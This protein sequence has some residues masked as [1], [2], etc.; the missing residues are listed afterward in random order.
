MRPDRHQ[1]RNPSRLR[2]SPMKS[3]RPSAFTTVSNSRHALKRSIGSDEDWE[4]R[5]KRIERALSTSGGSPT[6]SM[7]AT[8]P[9]MGQRSTSTSA[10]R[11][12]DL[13]NAAPCSSIW[14]CPKNLSSSTWTT[15]APQTPCHAPPRDVWID[16]AVFRHSDRALC[17]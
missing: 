3:T 16:R 9:S 15:T 14:P 11:S 7:K 8:A 10:M 1:G 4:N 17:R 5:H 2:A 6:G 12:A 13:G